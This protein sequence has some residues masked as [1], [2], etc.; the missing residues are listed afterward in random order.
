LTQLTQM[1]LQN[2]R[3]VIGAHETIANK[4]DAY[5]QSC[6][7]TQLK[8]IFQQDAVAARQSKQK[9]MTFLQ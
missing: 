6:N 3:H 5:A 1:E 8:Q 7:D 2:L 9:L 4:L